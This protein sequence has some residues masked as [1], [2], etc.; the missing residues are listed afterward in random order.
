MSHPILCLLA[1]LWIFIAGVR[2]GRMSHVPPSYLNITTHL[3]VFLV[4]LIFGL[5]FW[6]VVVSIEFIDWLGDKPKPK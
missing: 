3:D 6:P 2:I 1:L 4:W 5:L